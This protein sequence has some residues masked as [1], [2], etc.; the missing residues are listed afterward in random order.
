MA[1]VLAVAGLTIANGSDNI[2]VYM[3][4]LAN[5]DPLRL[6]VILASFAV[7]TGLWCLL[8]WCLT[9]TSLLNGL[10]G[11]IRRDLAPLLLMVIGG[12]VLYDSHTFS[13]PPL[14]IVAIACLGVMATSLLL[15][16]RLLSKSRELAGF[17]QR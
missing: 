13:T 10:L 5:S 7:L 17:P 1:G 6:R 14:A 12:L 3:A 9:Q 4:M 15:Q 11:R 2:S 16:L 8:A